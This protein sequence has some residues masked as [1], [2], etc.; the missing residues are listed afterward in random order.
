MVSVFA[1]TISAPGWIEPDSPPRW[2]RLADGRTVAAWERMV[3]AAVWIA[4]EDVLAPDGRTTPG[5]TTIHVEQGL[6]GMRPDVARR[7]AAE[8]LTAAATVY[9]L[10]PHGSL[11]V[12][13]LQAEVLARQP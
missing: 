7:L 9:A 2:L 13:A 12:L 3:S 4:R 5:E 10:A 1:V 6:D 8:L 11:N